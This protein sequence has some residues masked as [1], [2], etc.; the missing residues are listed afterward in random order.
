MAQDPLVRTF[1]RFCSQITKMEMRKVCGALKGDEKVHFP[2]IKAKSLNHK[3]ISGLWALNSAFRNISTSI[4]EKVDCA[5]EWN[6]GMHSRPQIWMQSKASFSNL[7]ACS[8][9]TFLDLLYLYGHWQMG[10]C[11]EN[12]IKWCESPTLCLKGLQTNNSFQMEKNLDEFIKMIIL[13]GKRTKNMKWW[14]ELDGWPWAKK[15]FIWS[16]EANCTVAASVGN[17]HVLQIGR[18]KIRSAKAQRKSASPVG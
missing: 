4:C 14:K 10:A 9:H 18:Q 1:A 6:E 16:A 7:F 15:M 2:I 11:H 12:P 3:R 13:H 5:E 17:C 8:L